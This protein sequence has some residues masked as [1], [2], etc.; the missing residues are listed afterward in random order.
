MVGGNLHLYDYIVCSFERF[1]SLT[2]KCLRGH[3][4][5][6]I[7]LAGL[8]RHGLVK[9]CSYIIKYYHVFFI[10]NS[11]SSHYCYCYLALKMATPV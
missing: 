1:R 3:P 11:S 6:G 10:A 5:F 7:V 4:Q 9:Y 8:F 2:P